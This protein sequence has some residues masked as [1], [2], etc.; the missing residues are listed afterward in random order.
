MSL[1]TL[2]NYWAKKSIKLSDAFEVLITDTVGKEAKPLVH[3]TGFT[4]PKLEYEE[5]TLEYGNVAQ[6]FLT[7]KYD[8]CKELTLEFM[9]HIE[10]NNYSVVLSKIFDYMGYKV[11]Q[12]YNSQGMTTNS[13]TY[14]IDKV[15][16]IID[17]K[18][19]NNKLW[20]YIYK[21]HF[22]NLKV[23]NYSIYN[24]DNQSET[25]CK[26]SVTLSFETYNKEIIDE[27]VEYL[28]VDNSKPKEE[29]KPK[30]KKEEQKT[31]PT[32]E[33]I[34]QQWKNDT[35]QDDLDMIRNEQLYD[36]EY[37]ELP[38]LD[39]D[40]EPDLAVNS[41]K[42]SMQESDLDMIRQPELEEL[43]A[44]EREMGGIDDTP[45]SNPDVGA[46]PAPEE[47]W[48]AKAYE[49][50]QAAKGNRSPD[51]TQNPNPETIDNVKTNTD[52]ANKSDPN[53]MKKQLT[54]NDKMENIEKQLNA[55]KDENSL[56]WEKHT[57]NGETYTDKYIQTTNG[58]TVDATHNQQQ[59]EA[60]QRAS[61]QKT[62]SMT[63]GPSMGTNGPG[64]T[65]S[66][67]EAAAAASAKAKET[68]D[69]NEYKR[70]TDE[71]AKQNKGHRGAVP[72]TKNIS[73]AHQTNDSES[74][75]K[76]GA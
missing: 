73:V 60:T 65:R 14:E 41:Y 68:A 72:P 27:K 55:K 54:K 21:Y 39:E 7:P 34:E 35:N 49:A 25:P 53:E 2:P 48:R 31:S 42:E 6:V 74:F 22:E 24:L 43:N 44:M 51:L 52:I 33:D 59:Y 3:C 15:I 32:K 75:Y 63:R 26:V 12:T 47:D 70:K 71:Y 4:I 18:I 76:N 50:Q 1:I 38:D 62:Q 58:H 69:Q 28:E 45:T 36:P 11:E 8:S 10:G 9:E 20:K 5:E 61:E 46:E 30:E 23:V 67:S 56:L 17:I 57:E 66:S 64:D 29:Q 40:M 19:L 37:Y 13:G 16:P